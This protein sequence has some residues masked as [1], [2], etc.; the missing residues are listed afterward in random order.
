[1]RIILLGAPG[2]GKGT[3]AKVICD[4]FQIPQ[5]S[6]GDMLRSE[7]KS[8]TELG[9][10]AKKIMETGKLVNDEIIIKLALKR[11]LSTDCLEGYLFDGFPR[12]IPQA[13]ALK[14]E[15]VKIDLIIDIVVPDKEIINRI[16]GRR[17]HPNSG[18]TYHVDFNPPK[19]V[20]IDDITGEKLIQ[21]NDDTPETVKQ[22]LEVYHHQTRPLLNFYKK[23]ENNDSTAPK[24]MEVDGIGD[25]AQI[26]SR[27]LDVLD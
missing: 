25:I 3:Q 23:W 13:E 20:G 15:N 17:V 18:R 19:K 6:T 14:N 10:T 21:R 22:R 27:V 9:E 26:T 12:T 4:K 11:I 5:I 2:A 1:M 7:I 8:E 24:T 16:S